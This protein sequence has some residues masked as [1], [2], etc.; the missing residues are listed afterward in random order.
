MSIV[1]LNHRLMDHKIL[2]IYNNTPDPLPTT[3]A[4]K[5]RGDRLSITPF[6]TPLSVTNSFKLA[7]NFVSS[8]RRVIITVSVPRLVVITRYTCINQ[9]ARSR[10]VFRLQQLRADR[11]QIAERD[12]GRRK[13]ASCQVSLVRGLRRATLSGVCAR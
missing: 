7:L 13:T 10:T 5:S 3:G 8:P 4:K 11:V 12:D 2:T 1:K 9:R 6:T